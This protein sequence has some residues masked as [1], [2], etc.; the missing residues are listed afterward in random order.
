MTSQLTF[1]DLGDLSPGRADLAIHR[2]TAREQR[3][4]VS[5]VLTGSHC[6]PTPDDLETT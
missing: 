3:K 4:Y 6:C 5:V 1:E 2:E